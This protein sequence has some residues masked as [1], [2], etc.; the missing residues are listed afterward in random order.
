[1]KLQLIR[2][3]TFKM[4]YAG[5]TLL[6]DPMLCA[7]ETFSPFVP[8]LKKNPTVDLKMNA[9]D[10]L[11]D[12]DAVLVTHS[13]PDHFDS[14]TAEKLDKNFKI[15]G[16][17]ADKDFFSKQGFINIEQ[18]ESSSK[19]QDIQITRI[20]GQHGSGSILKFMGKVSGYVLKAKAEPT[21]YIVGDSILTDDVKNAIQEQKPDIIVTN[22][23]G[24]IIPNYEDFPVIMDAEQTIQVAKLA[25][26]AKIIAVHLE[27]IDFCRVT[28]KSLREYAEKNNIDKER[29][30]IPEDS[31]II[32]I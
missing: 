18:I 28:R 17:P 29:L 8:G 27:S 23:G 9:D 1:M 15:F 10:V 5:K 25:P 12:I 6:I 16:T 20:E 4:H 11:E 30:I 3:A 26:Q 19:W 22:S 14:A 31:E 7:K 21:I 2:N 32:I 13:H 24:G